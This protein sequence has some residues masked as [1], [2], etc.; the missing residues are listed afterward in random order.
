M[1]VTKNNLF[2]VIFIVVSIIVGFNSSS[3]NIV[4]SSVSVFMYHRFGD[5]RYP[6][7]NI[8]MNQ[9]KL[10]IKEITDNNYNII[11]IDEVIS[12][13]QNN[14]PFKDKSVS[15]SV[16]DAHESF[17]LNG[18]PIFKI[19]NIPV[20]L[21]VSTSIVDENIPGYM[22]WD[23]IR[24]FIND[25]GN[26]GQHTANHFHMPTKDKPEIIKDLKESHQRFFEELGFIPKAFAFPYGEASLEVIKTLKEINI[27]SAFGQHSGVI[28]NNSNSYYLPRYA[29]NE[30]FGG[31][32]RFI[33]AANSK[34]LNVSSFIPND[35]YLDK[36][37]YNKIEFNIP[38][39]MDYKNINCYANFNEEWTE[40][41]LIELDNNRIQFDLKKYFD[42]GRRRFN[43]TT[44]FNNEWY[45]F[46]YQFLVK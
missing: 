24:K 38:H 9:F 7:T 18:W 5:D 41:N 31:I 12:N 22:T 10:H 1:K 20:T 26:I 46:G 19:N 42:P 30:N 16:D 39:H 40:I 13:L 44:K 36:K 3:Q 37:N 35:M 2:F 25:G 29:I 11:S 4:N 33:F 45:W 27:E 43:C 17:F 6:S 34:A 14:F 21:F 8:K 28:S 15:F 23:Q 32:D